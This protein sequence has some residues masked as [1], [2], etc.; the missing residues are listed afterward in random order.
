MSPDRIVDEYAS[1]QFGA[2]S[3]QQAE[4]AGF[5]PRMILTRIN[6]GAWIRLAPGVY[7]LAS[8]PPKWDRQLA[9]ALL[10]REGS[11]AAGRSA[12]Y[13]HEFPGFGPARPV[14]MIGADGNARSPLA[15]VIRS[16]RFDEVGRVRKR[17][18]LAT[19]EAETV[20]TL[21][22]SLDKARL[23]ALV[24]YS[25][26]RGSCNVDQLARVVAANVGAR[27]V[28]NLRPIV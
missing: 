11:I 2:F 1:R 25:L 4:Q 17:G 16:H 12:A 15:R 23:E 13:L 28:A 20:M 27:G 10:T 7:A 21:A 18:F 22:A 26:A 24:D 5:S 9:A 19:D 6:N 8:A 14:I 3:R